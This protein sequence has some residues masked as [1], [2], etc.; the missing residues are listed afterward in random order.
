[1][2]CLEGYIGIQ[3]CGTS[4]PESGV[5]INSLPGIS[6]EVAQKIADG[7]QITF[8]NAW[9]DITARAIRR[10]KTDVVNNLKKR[11]RLSI[12]SKFIN[13]GKDLDTSVV[14]AA[15]ATWRG[16]VIQV[17]GDMPSRLNKIYI[18]EVNIYFSGAVNT[19]LK[20]VD[21][22]GN[23]Q[24]TKTVTTTGAGWKRVY[25]GDT[26]DGKTLWV[27]YDST[28]I[29]S[30]KTV[31]D[32]Y[33]DTNGDCYCDAYCDYD[34]D[35][36]LRTTGVIITDITDIDTFVEGSNTYGLSIIYGLRCAYDAAICSNR[37]EFIEPL[38]MVHGVEFLSE[39]IYSTRVNRFT[40]I[41]LQKA[42]DLRT[43]LEG[44]YQSS[45]QAVLDGLMIDESDCC[46]ECQWVTRYDQCT[47]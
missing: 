31:N 4:T 27:V 25:I 8:L 23:V 46:I 13:T 24:S 39:R 44:I 12:I 26:F 38:Q 43:E 32:V 45:L 21:E 2:E 29:N 5:Y 10:F 16:R 15:S 17:V 36:K 35:C 33:T 11:F 1:M 42:K 9:N 3:G 47:P 28:A 40:T 14:T 37:Q 19:T 41:D 22:Y 18:E 20:I 7:E 6:I 30:V 34:C